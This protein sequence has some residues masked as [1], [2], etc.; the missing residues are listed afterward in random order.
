MRWDRTAPT[1]PSNDVTVVVEVKKGMKT[2]FDN[3]EKFHIPPCEL[4]SGEKRQNTSH[5]LTDNVHWWCVVTSH[6]LIM[7]I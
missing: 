7:F 3:I 2:R 6:S 4:V 1:A 5:S